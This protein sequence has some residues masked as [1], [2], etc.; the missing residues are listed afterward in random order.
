M[1]VLVTY[2]VAVSEEGRSAQITESAVSPK[3]ELSQEVKQE[4][5]TSTDSIITNYETSLVS[6][7][8]VKS[9]WGNFLSDLAPHN[10]SVAGLLR[11]TSPVA[12][13]PRP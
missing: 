13:Y 1:F 3:K 2:D 4:T 7:D 6:I 12:R 8:R 5:E 9:E 10:Q 11:A